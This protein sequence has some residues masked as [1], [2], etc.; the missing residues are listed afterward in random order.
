MPNHWLQDNFHPF[1]I[2]ALIG[3]FLAYILVLF[4]IKKLQ[5]E[6]PRTRSQ[7]MLLP[8][9]IPA[10][11][12]MA[13]VFE[14]APRCF[15]L[16]INSGS[17]SLDSML[18]GLC[19]ASN[20]MA[21][22]VTPLFFLAFAFAFIRVAMGFTTSHRL[23]RK[24]GFATL[25]TQSRIIESAQNLAY[26]GKI[27]IP[28]IVVTP[29][30]FGQAFTFGYR[31][32]VIVLSQGLI[33]NLD[34]EE[35][36]AVLAHEL[37]HIIRKDAILNWIAVFLRD[38]MF[39]APVTYWVYNYFADENEKASDDITLQLTDKPLA[40][41]A[42]LIK[43][44][45]LSPKSLWSRLMW[46][47]FSPNPGLVKKAGTLQIRVER[48]MNQV[49]HLRQPSVGWVAGGIVTSVTGVLFLVC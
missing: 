8:L 23:I 30:L 24:F 12:S 14:V 4:V 34:D 22:L 43:V 39:F 45:K 31:K 47:N 18:Q 5:I 10:F 13:R 11:T 16:N 49:D 48:V 25:A 2:Y 19:T 7:L 20:A 21:I 41:A 37:A 9:V 29:Y 46:N 40:F 35:L 17:Q 38:L 44:W 33:D 6:N 36:E 27:E 28:Q 26:K 3:S 15:L 32:P 42:A 1:I